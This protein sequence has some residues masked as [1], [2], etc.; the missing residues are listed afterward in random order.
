MATVNTKERMECMF[1]R[2]CDHV[3]L[4]VTGPWPGEWKGP[5]DQVR[6]ELS[7]I[8]NKQ[9]LTLGLQKARPEPFQAWGGPSLTV[10]CNNLQTTRHGDKRILQTSEGP[11]LASPRY[12]I[13]YVLICN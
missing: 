10:L 12:V 6:G 13:E 9:D 1:M 4:Q 11:E 3:L 7:D 2:I 8:F 5:R